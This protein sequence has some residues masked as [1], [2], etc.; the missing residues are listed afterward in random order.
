VLLAIL[1]CVVGARA[2]E[3]KLLK[4][5]LP[6]DGTFGNEM[7]ALVSRTYVVRFES[8]LVAD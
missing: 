7:D 1:D 5:V 4:V 6:V 8:K 3:S 2:P